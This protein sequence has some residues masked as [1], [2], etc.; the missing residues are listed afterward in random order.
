LEKET[1]SSKRILKIG[2]CLLVAVF[3]QTSLKNIHPWFGYIDWLL[4][5]TV[6][7]GL[8]REPVAALLTGTAAGML[9][10]FSSLVPVVGVGGMGNLLAGY[11]AYWV[12]SAFFVEGLLI[13]SA[14]VIGASVIAVITRLFFYKV[15]LKYPLPSTAALE[16]I[17]GPVL[18]FLLSFVLFPTLDQVFSVGGRARL[19]RAEARRG[20]R[21]RKWKVK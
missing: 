17:W 20:L 7:I 6:Y 19:R 12:S 13:R 18:T 11:V 8:M 9:Y 2:V 10:D 16:L 15:I 5:V 1:H 4:L 21:R 3:A 14:T